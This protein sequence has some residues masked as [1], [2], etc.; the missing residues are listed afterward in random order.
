MQVNG[1]GIGSVS[2]KASRSPVCSLFTSRYTYALFPIE[3]LLSSLHCIFDLPFRGSEFV[4]RCQRMR[5]EERR[6]VSTTAHGSRHTAYRGIVK[7]FLVNDTGGIIG[8]CTRCIDSAPT[9][10]QLLSFHLPSSSSSQLPSFLLPS[11]FLSSFQRAPQQLL[12][13]IRVYPPSTCRKHRFC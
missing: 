8:L 9:A 2:G 5:G 10:R 13:G 3:T 7:R 6:T 12:Q 4:R 1:A 11:S